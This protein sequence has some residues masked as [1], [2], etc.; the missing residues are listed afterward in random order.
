MK[1][2]QFE[3]KAQELFK[4]FENRIYK[5]LLQVM[6]LDF[7]FASC[8][9]QIRQYVIAVLI[10]KFQ[11]YVR[12]FFIRFHILPKDKCVSVAQHS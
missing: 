9:V 7:F 10:Y 11:D 8:S 6:L 12:G 1:E 3:Q 2:L 4:R 5:F